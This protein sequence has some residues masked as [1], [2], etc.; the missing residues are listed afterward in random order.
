MHSGLRSLT[1]FDEKTIS[2][3]ASSIFDKQFHFIEKE[4][5]ICVKTT[6]Q[7][8]V[9]DTVLLF[10]LVRCDCNTRKAY[11]SLNVNSIVFIPTD[12]FL[13]TCLCDVNKY[14][15]LEYRLKEHKVI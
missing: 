1:F 13:Y 14:L 3:S 11:C 5:I 15:L 6:K 12:M 2:Q 4:H 9:I 8:S 10:K 7:I